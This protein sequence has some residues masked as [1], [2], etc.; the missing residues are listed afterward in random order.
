MYDVCII[1]GGASGMSTAIAAAKR[2]L[3]VI[4]IDRNNKLGKKLYA[5]GNGK[6]NIT[7]KN[8]DYKTKY[9]SMSDDYV[10]FLNESI[11][12][13]P[14]EDIID[15]YNSLGVYTYANGDYVYPNSLQASSVVWAMLDKLNELNIKIVFKEEIV[16]I[17]KVDKGFV[18]K[19][20]NDEIRATQVV[21]ACGSRSYEKLGGTVEGYKLAR[22]FGHSIVKVRPALCGMHTSENIKA[23]SGVR[24]RATAT[25]I[26]NEDNVSLSESG[27]LQFTDYGI[28]GI[29]IFNLSSVVG[30]YL[31]NDKTVKVRVNLIPDVLEENILSMYKHADNRTV[32]GFLNGFVND[33][34]ASFFITKHDIN[35]KYN[36]KDVDINKIIDIFQNMSSCE[37][38]IKELCD[39]DNAQICAGG[40]NIE[41]INPKN[42]MSNKVENL[43]LVGEML[44]IDGVCGGYNITFAVLS[45]LKAGN[46]LNKY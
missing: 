8:M 26:N 44:D 37:F 14:Y 35:P 33:K 24:V 1:G 30:R 43:Y 17:C 31:N 10:D 46:N 11:G 45:G 9:H 36:V 27:E 3:R 29:L 32:L 23:L 4:I 42:M 28:S 5:T 6:C 2:G 25:V 21:L 22:N 18:I 12:M 39:F 41:E 19:S 40:V 7:N 34:I 16:S 20:Q 38:D 13:T 15:F